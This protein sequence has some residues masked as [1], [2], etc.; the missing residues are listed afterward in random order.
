MFTNLSFGACSTG[1]DS[2]PFKNSGKNRCRGCPTTCKTLPSDFGYI[3]AK[4]LHEHSVSNPYPKYKATHTKKKKPAKIPGF[5]RMFTG[6]GGDASQPAKPP[7]PYCR[8]PGALRGGRRGPAPP[9]IG[10]F[11]SS[12]CL[13][14]PRVA[15][16]PAGRPAPPPPAS[17]L[18]LAPAPRTQVARLY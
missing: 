14:G 11:P 16:S 6:H 13:S 1:R 10:D 15:P 17:G 2:F 8:H 18:S 3:N 5:C 9:S 4:D 7:P 12:L